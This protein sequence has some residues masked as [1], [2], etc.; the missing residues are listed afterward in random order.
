MYKPLIRKLLWC[1][2]LASA[3]AFAA[4]VDYS[5]LKFR[6]IGVA[7]VSGRVSDIAVHPEKHATW[8][9]AAASGG[10]WKTENAGTTWSP[11]FDGQAS[12]SIGALA[13]DESR[14]NVIWVGTGENN[15]QRSVSYGDGV[16]KSED[17]G[18]SWQHMGLKDSEHIG[19]IL[20]HPE[21]SNTIFVA[22]QGPLWRDGGERGLYRSRDAGKTWQRVLHISDKTGV[23][24]VI[25]DPRNPDVLYA[26]SYQRR[27]HVWTLINGG[28][29]S[30]IY[31]SVDGGDTWSKVENGLPKE[32][33][34]KI[35][36]A[37]APSNPDIIYAIVES[38]NDKGGFY[39]STNGGQSW[40]KRSGYM[41]QSPQYYNEIF[42]DPHNAE[43]IYS[44]DT[45]LHASEDGGKTFE[46]LGSGEKWKHVDNHA[47]W[48]DPHN[49]D[50]LV[51]GCDGGIYV[52][53]DRGET[54]DFAENLP[55]AQFYRGS[56]DYDLPFY[57][58]YGGTQDN[59]SFGVPSRTTDK[60]GITNG[61]MW[62]TQMGD[63]FKTQVDPTDA[64]V[65][66]S[67]A[68]HGALVRYDRASGDALDI[69]PQPGVGESLRFNWDSPLIISPHNHKRL[70]FAAQKLFRSDDRGHSWVAVSDDLTR[71]LDRNTL[72]VMGRIWA[73]ETVAK[74]ASTSFY[75]S[76]VSLSES[77]LR[78]G[79]LYVGTDDGLIQVSENG[80]QSWRKIDE[81]KGVDKLAYVSDIEAS[82]H[83]ENTVYASF[84]NHKN[85]DFKPYVLVSRDRGKSWKRIDESLPA[86][87]TV[88]ALAQDH[89]NAKLLFA[90]TEFGVY[91]SQNDGESWQQLKGGLP[92]IAIRDI[93]IQ[94]RESDLV[95]ASFG[96]GFYVLDDYSALRSAP[97]AA[98]LYPPRR[99]W[100]YPV[101]ARL[102]LAGKSMSGDTY[103]ADD[104]PPHGAV[105]TYYLPE[106]LQSEK[107]KRLEQQGKT[108]EKGGDT[109]YPSWQQLEAEDREQAPSVTLTVTDLDGNV[110]RR[111]NGPVKKGFHRVEWDLRLP[112]M[113]P[114]ALKPFEPSSAFDS[115]P[116]GPLV[117]PGQYTVAI[118][119][120]VNGVITA[121]SS[122]QTFV[123]EHTNILKLK[124]EDRDA[125]LAFQRQVAD[126]FR[127]VL[128]ADR[129]I[130]D[131]DA[132]ISHLHKAYERTPG[133][134]AALLNDL[135]ALEQRLLDLR[136]EFYG[137][138]TVAKR[139]EPA[140][141]GIRSRVS[142]IVGGSFESHQAPTVTHQQ[143]FV[144]ASELFRTFLGNLKTFVQ[145]DLQ[146]LEARFEQLDAP[147][148][149]QRFPEWP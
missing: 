90:G 38:I 45:F 51:V 1:S 44:M 19:K 92:T 108:K 105:F 100:M 110:I 95:L 10:I 148:T 67:Q 83:D 2:V 56:V 3:T 42:V 57:N 128:S 49:T 80:G 21:D 58:I 4:D 71:K 86:R 15:S 18:A 31:K 91:F 25:M 107:D 54:W 81:F 115:E 28:P 61:D 89:L 139:N 22:S 109:P 12:Y 129:I 101:K 112:S 6:N 122:P 106:S 146:K 62:I 111:V 11:I 30:T 84:D 40:E 13:I 65:V 53:W 87:G 46:R 63:G 119:Q 37:L 118:E 140:A 72:K 33:K 121:L 116:Q 70:Y 82:Q 137:D 94:R 75:G 69:Q 39:R 142:N 78:D 47:M 138:A 125:V 17:N 103:Y 73:P 135:R 124:P 36:L 9:V 64:N 34:G 7:A 145:G 113:V 114:A 102:A 16:Y 74:N 98:T 132:R 76:I 144:L 141:P 52:T 43:R 23:N 99:T 59:A 120:R 32:D 85:G 134:N 55:L 123:V 79:L 66:Y 41:S 149:P 77:P 136:E 29:E 26:S 97:K 27:R 5:G 143:Q 126:L 35:G 93:D 88:Y 133:A 104:N 127:A 24:E 131:T 14:P 48:I 8:Y 147:H 60:A 96:R 68:Q 130:K 117:V 50:H 20:I